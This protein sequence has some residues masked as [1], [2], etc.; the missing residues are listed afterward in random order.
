MTSEIRVVLVDDQALVRTGL[1]MVVDAVDDMRVVGEA[2]DGSQAL[3]V[4]ATTPCDIVLMDVRMPTMDGV[5]A[6]RE[7]VRRHPSGLPRVVVLTTF[8]L[9]EYAFAALRVG[10]SGFLLKDAPAEDVIAAIRSVHAGD[11]VIA[12]STTRRLLDHVA[13]DLPATG[14]DDGLDALTHRELA[15]M[16]EIA[17]GATNSEI[18]ASLFLAE[19]TVKTHVGRILSKLALRDRVQIVIRAYETGLVGRGRTGPRSAG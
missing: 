5:A 15:V 12:A 2:A 18:A 7:L 1:A 4:I 10:A 14:G 8:D 9:D 19:A 11:A 17:R 6:T 13:A 3:D 16:V